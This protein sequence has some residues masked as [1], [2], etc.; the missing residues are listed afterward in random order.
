MQ[1]LKIVDMLQR[2]NVVFNHHATID[3]NI[4]EHYLVALNWL[5]NDRK[6][7]KYSNSS[8]IFRS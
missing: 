8:Q 7:G 1:R 4:T 3:E 6:L 5:P 2:V